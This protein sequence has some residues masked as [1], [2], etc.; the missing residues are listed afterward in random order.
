MS[1]IQSFN[2][3]Q[4]IVRDAR[5]TFMYKPKNKNQSLVSTLCIGWSVPDRHS[6]THKEISRYSIH[7]LGRT[8]ERHSFGLCS[9]ATE[10]TSSEC[11][12]TKWRIS[13]VHLF[14]LLV[15]IICWTEFSS[16]Q[17]KQIKHFIFILSAVSP[18][19]RPATASLS[20]YK[21]KKKKKDFFFTAILV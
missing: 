17:I 1:L 3:I 15:V 13:T 8:K 19:C 7:E 9:T 12:S 16:T 6:N 2:F 4:R 14:C 20:S 10:N 11:D 21:K 18:L 5:A